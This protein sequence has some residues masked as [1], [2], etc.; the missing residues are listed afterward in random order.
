VALAAGSSEDAAAWIYKVLAAASML[1]AAVLAAW[2]SRRW[3]A[4]ALAFVGWNPVLALHFAGGGHNDA[5][6]AALVLGALAL[7]GAARW[8]LSGAVWSLAVLVKWVPALFLPLVVAGARRKA[9]YL[10]LGLASAVVAALASLR[11]GWDWLSAFGPLAANA[12]EETSYSIPNR[13]QQAG[14]HQL[15]AV[16]ACAA[17]FVVAYALLLR[18]AAR[19][20]TRLALVGGLFL[21]ATPWLAAWYTAWVIPLAAA[22]EDRAAR[23]LA[24]ALCVYLAPQAVPT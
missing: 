23:V 7:A 17:V 20:R 1:V 5:W 3:R 14:L 6:I 16:T 19:G 22:E 24:F 10:G 2:L 13:L 18:E 4:F 9:G 12:A 8:N 15:A 21:L 11:Y